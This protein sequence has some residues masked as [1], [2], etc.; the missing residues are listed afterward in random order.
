[1]LEY[2][3]RILAFDSNI[4]TYFLNGNAGR[5]D[6][7]RDA[8]LTDQHIAAVRLFLYCRPFIPPTVRAEALR[9]PNPRKA[10]EHMRFIDTNFGEIVPDE[11]QKRAIE[12]RA[13]ALQPHH[14]EHDLDDCRIVAEI[15]VDGAVPVL[16]TN[17][18]KLRNL[19]PHTVIRLERPVDYWTNLGIPRGTPPAW[20]PAPSHPLS[21]ETWWR[22]E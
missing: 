11:N 9:I 16:V 13:L 5:Y 6:W 2:N 8:T 17:D 7:G 22:W 3:D 10:E 15:E 20:T 4:L 21:R 12:V 14:E 1:V 19:A 18:R